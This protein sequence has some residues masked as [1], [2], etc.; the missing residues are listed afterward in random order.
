MADILE[1]I[2]NKFCFEITMYIC[3]YLGEAPSAK[4]I[5]ECNKQLEFC[6]EKIDD[7]FL[8][9]SD[10]F[11]FFTNWRRI[12]FC[13]SFLFTDRIINVRKTLKNALIGCS[14]CG[15]RCP[16]LKEY[17]EY[18]KKCHW[19]YSKNFR[20][21]FYNCDDCNELTTIF[22]R[23]HNTSNGLFCGSCMETRDENGELETESESENE[24]EIYF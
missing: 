14:D 3:K 23:F 17:I 19:C 22:G 15:R 8:F 20:E 6:E 12:K 4:I 11:D 9:E 1:I 5:R 7:E 10:D 18:D 24:D 2:N 13:Q 16:S 21:E